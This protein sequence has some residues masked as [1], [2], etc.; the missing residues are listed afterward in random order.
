M[1][2]IQVMWD[3][4][5][6]SISLTSFPLSPSPHLKPITLYGPGMS[7][8]SLDQLANLIQIFLFLPTSLEDLTI[9][10][11]MEEEPPLKD[12]ISSYVYQCGP[13]LRRFHSSISLSETAIHCLMQLPN[14]CF[15]GT[16]QA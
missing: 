2:R 13:S 10:C 12:A 3:I 8:I 14:L 11:G 16:S 9:L 5:E 6:M 1:L 4:Y 7:D 15:W